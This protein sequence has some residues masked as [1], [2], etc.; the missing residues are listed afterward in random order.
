MGS[1]AA[2]FFPSGVKQAQLAEPVYHRYRADNDENPIDGVGGP[3]AFHEA[4]KVVRGEEEV[5]K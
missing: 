2:V 4:E 3:P 1:N 5:D